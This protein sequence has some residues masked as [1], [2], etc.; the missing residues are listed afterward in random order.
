M[1]RGRADLS[2]KGDPA[3]AMVHLDDGRLWFAD[4]PGNMLDEAEQP[5]HLR[6]RFSVAY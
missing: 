5:R 6:A 3:D 2:P 4:R 1:P